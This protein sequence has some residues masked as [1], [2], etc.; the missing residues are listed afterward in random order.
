MGQEQKKK[1][2]KRGS[3][4]HWSLLKSLEQCTLTL[5][6]LRWLSAPRIPQADITKV[7]LQKKKVKEKA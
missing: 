7:K 3:P 2:I 6:T 1:G 5:A 4:E